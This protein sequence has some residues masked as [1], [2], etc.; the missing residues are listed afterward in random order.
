MAELVGQHPP[1]TKASPWISSTDK[2]ESAFGNAG[3]NVSKKEKKRT[4]K[5]IPFHVGHPNSTISSSKD[6]K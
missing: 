3:P 4:V 1:K 6:V 2:L 5:E